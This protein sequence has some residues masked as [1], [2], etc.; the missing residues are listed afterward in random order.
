MLTR[1]DPGVEGHLHEAIAADPTYAPAYV[2]LAIG[3]A[4]LGYWGYMPLDVAYPRAKE[5]GL[6]A[7]QLD[8]SS[9]R[10][11]AATGFI[12]WLLDWDLAG[13]ER[14]MRRGLEL[15]PSDD[16]VHLAYSKFLLVIAGRRDE[17]IAEGGWPLN[18]TRC[19]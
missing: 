16:F 6:R 17:A 14:H 10:G 19:R 4:A 12:T 8:E 1:A 5:A 15:S 7:L 11:H 13:C 2:E 3:L 9:G 18:S